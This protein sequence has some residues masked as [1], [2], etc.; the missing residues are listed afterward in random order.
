MRVTSIANDDKYEV[1]LIEFIAPACWTITHFY[2]LIKSPN[3]CL[4]CTNS[5][6]EAL[7]YNMCYAS[8]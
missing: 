8:L 1:R 3:I 5:Y 7:L 2:Q 4:G 6:H